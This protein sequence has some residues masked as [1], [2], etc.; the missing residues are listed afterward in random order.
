[1]TQDRESKV[2]YYTQAFKS[3]D[4]LL[5]RHLC[6]TDLFFLIYFACRRKDLNKDWLFD[7]CNE[8]QA[9]P[10]GYLD[11]WSREHYKSTIITFGLT[12]Q[13]ILNNPNTTIGIFSHTRPIAKAFMSQ[14]KTEFEN[15]NYLKS[16]FKDI[17]YDDPRKEASKWSLDDGICVKRTE[18]P[19][20]QTIEAWGLVDGQPTSKHYK[21]LV[22]DD[23]VV[24]DSVSTPEMIQ[25]V[26]DSWALSLNLASG[27]A[28]KRYVGTRYHSADT[29]ATI[30][31]RKAAIPRV[32]AATIDGTF[33]GQTSFWT[34]EQFEKKVEEMGT[35]VAAAQLLLNPLSDK[36]QSFQKEWIMFY[37]ILKNIEQWNTYILVDPANAKKKS[38]DF[39]DIKVIGLAPDNNYYLLYALRDRMNLTERT[40]K[41]F[42]L[43][44]IWKPLDVGYEQYGMQCDIQHIQYVQEQENYRFHI[45]PLSGS[46]N[47]T[48][49]IK[50]LVPVFQKFRMYFPHRIHFISLDGK[51]HD[52]ITEF[53]SNEYLTFP[54][55]AHDDGL[56]NLANILHPDLNAQFPKVTSVNPIL[57][58][59]HDTGIEVAQGLLYDPLKQM[60]LSK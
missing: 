29:Y 14:I 34:K 24:K 51:V 20:E 23:I 10:D 57:V 25:K 16:I 19:K 42:E 54:V 21:V 7:R 53:I 45:S 8:V 9:N 4:G 46:T 60:E 26:T 36:A 49:R 38:S 13:E 44:R 12:I 17:L 27:D 41:L 11:L 48:D 56:D 35:W 31:E 37:D 18:N 32:H 5:Q 40:K 47:K 6:K 50:R 59:L 52:Y 15:N 28:K 55:C 39:T 3:F 33:T 58:P 1:M 2:A 22:Y 30:I 43:H